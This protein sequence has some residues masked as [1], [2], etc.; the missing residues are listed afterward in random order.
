MYKTDQKL[1]RLSITGQCKLKYSRLE[2]TV[3]MVAAPSTVIIPCQVTLDTDKSSLKKYYPIQGVGND[4]KFRRLLL[5]LL[6]WP[7]KSYCFTHF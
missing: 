7:E 3:N 1:K 5:K 2:K 6:I 4:L